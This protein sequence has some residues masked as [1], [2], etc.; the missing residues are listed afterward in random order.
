VVLRVRPSGNV[1][2]TRADRI[3]SSYP[4]KH[5]SPNSPVSSRYHTIHI[6]NLARAKATPITVMEHI[7]AP[8]I[9]AKSMIL[10]ENAAANFANVKTNTTI[11]LQV[12]YSPSKP[13]NV[14]IV[15]CRPPNAYTTCPMQST[16]NNAA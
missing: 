13:H 16:G 15:D 4:L 2:F 11:D 12:M 3:L 14:A 5:S 7:S 8:L 1:G 6:R 10:P 9:S